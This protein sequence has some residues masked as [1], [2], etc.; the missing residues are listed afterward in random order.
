MTVAGCVRSV[1]LADMV[2]L[3]VNDEFTVFA[4]TDLVGFSHR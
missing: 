3:W 4:E 2:W 1:E